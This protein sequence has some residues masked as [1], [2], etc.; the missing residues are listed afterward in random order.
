MP[1]IT[2]EEKL[3]QEILTEAKTKADRLLA[4]AR[5]K[6]DKVVREATEAVAAAR[7]VRLQE[8]QEELASQRRAIEVDV[9]RETHRHELLQREACLE[10][11]FARALQEVSAKTGEE[12]AESYRRLAEEVLLAIGNGEIEVTFP[13]ADAGIVTEGWLSGIASKSVPGGEFVFRL[14]PQEG[15][16][17][18]LRF[19]RSD[20]S[21]EF[22]NTY[23]ARLEAMKDDL[24]LLV[25][26]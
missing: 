9:A 22:D 3:R 21:R 11:L 10:E 8:V 24:R 7:E 25:I 26:Q 16:P 4:R 14:Q 6:A 13:A 19:K 5:N 12:R 18:G 20:G 15:A 17:A 2:Q 1:E 23:A